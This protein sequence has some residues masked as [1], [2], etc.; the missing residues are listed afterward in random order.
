[1]DSHKFCNSLLLI[2][3]I[4][5]CFIKIWNDFTQIYVEKVRP[6]WFKLPLH[7]KFEEMFS[8]CIIFNKAL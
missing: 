3:S 4:L 8:H 6:K 7:V 1:M 2:T 5:N